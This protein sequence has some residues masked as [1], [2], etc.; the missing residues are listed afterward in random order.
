[1]PSALQ[2]RVRVPSKKVQT[3]RPA[4]QWK[5]RAGPDKAGV[6][7]C[8]RSLRR[9]GLVAAR[10]CP[11]RDRQARRSRPQPSSRRDAVAPG[12]SHLMPGPRRGT[13]RRAP[14]THRP[15]RA[16]GLATAPRRGSAA[17]TWCRHTGPTPPS[18]FQAP[19]RA[20]RRGL[21]ELGCPA[22]ELLC[23][24]G[25]G[26]ATAGPPVSPSASAA[27]PGHPLPPA[28]P[29][30]LRP[31]TRRRET[32]RALGC[33][34]RFLLGLASPSMIGCREPHVTQKLRPTPG[35]GDVGSA[36]KEREA[37]TN[38]RLVL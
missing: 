12:L 30:P 28:P 1:M 15:C 29:L 17:C 20:P 38:R 31:G 14:D 36:H 4:S 3:R 33:G 19:P 37:T 24:C 11:T 10:L 25:P 35:L 32:K 7:F 26:L 27:V 23:R 13:A 2:L 34:F 5:Q 22:R 21:R 8:T 6:R 9:C 18:C 16:V